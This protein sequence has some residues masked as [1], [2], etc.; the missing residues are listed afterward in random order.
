MLLA[1]RVLVLAVQK[2]HIES[3]E[4]RDRFKY[5]GWMT[6]NFSFKNQL[7]VTGSVQRRLYDVRKHDSTILT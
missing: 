1:V 7:F 4:T 6:M 5:F 2:I 3:M